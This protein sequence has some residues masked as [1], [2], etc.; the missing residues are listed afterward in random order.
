[1]CLYN[2]YCDELQ[3]E[4]LSSWKCSC[5]RNVPE[6]L[7]VVPAWGPEKDF[8]DAWIRAKFLQECPSS[9]TH[10]W[11]D[12]ASERI[13]EYLKRS[14]WLK[15]ACRPWVPEKVPVLE[16]GLKSL[17][18]CKSSG[19]DSCGGNKPEC[20]EF[21]KEF[22]VPEKVPSVEKCVK[23]LSSWKSSWISEK[24]PAAEASSSMSS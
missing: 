12:W 23:V 19:K 9:W 6:I 20:P 16:M 7:F 5:S 1:M 24:V 3:K 13:L 4:L 14:L 11:N 10:D 21:L 15:H 18:L 8:C 17:N 2:V 22:Y